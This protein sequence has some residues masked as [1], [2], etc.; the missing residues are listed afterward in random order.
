MKEKADLKCIY[1]KDTEFLWEGG[2]MAK[3]EAQVE[4]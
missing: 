1:K 4:R 3:R 2:N